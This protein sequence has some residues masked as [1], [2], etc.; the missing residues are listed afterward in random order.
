MDNASGTLV[1]LTSA[2]AFPR[3]A[4]LVAPDVP[5]LSGFTEIDVNR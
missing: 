4:G 5:H 2:T 3:H 1:L